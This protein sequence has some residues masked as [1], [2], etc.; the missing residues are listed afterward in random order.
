MTCIAWSLAGKNSNINWFAHFGKE[1]TSFYMDILVTI[2]VLL[3]D[4]GDK[5]KAPALSLNYLEWI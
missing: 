5:I 1:A 3:I 2:L 4:H